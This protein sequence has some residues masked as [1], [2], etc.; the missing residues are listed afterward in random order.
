VE[1]QKFTRS[2]IFLIL[3]V[4]FGNLFIFGRMGIKSYF[5]KK[6]D[7][8]TQI[9]KISELEVKIENLNDEITRWKKDD[10]ELEKMAREELQ[11]GYPDEKVYILPKE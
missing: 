7:L 6:K 9:S 1:I 11:M 2:A 10:F 8:D 5:D 4:A 3:V